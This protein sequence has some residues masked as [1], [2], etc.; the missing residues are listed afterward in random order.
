MTDHDPTNQPDDRAQRA[1][2]DTLRSHADGPI[3][4]PLHLDV[5]AAPSP[6]RWTRWVPAAAVVALVALAVPLVLSQTG[7]GPSGA[8]PQ[9]ASGETAPAASSQA[10]APTMAASGGWRWESYKV[11]SYQ[12][13]TTWGYGYAPDSAWCV[14]EGRTAYGP[15]VDVATETRVVAAILCPRAIPLDRLP[16]FVSVRAAGAADRGY[17]LPAGW[18]AASTELN[19]YRLEVV[20][21]DAQQ[22]VA[23]EIVASV[24]PIGA[25]DPNGCPAAPTSLTPAYDI[26]DPEAGSLCQYDHTNQLLA[27]KPLDT[28][29]AADV[30]T[31]LAAAPNGSGPDEGCSDTRGDTTHVVVKLV[32]DLATQYV[33]VRYAGCRGNGTT[34]LGEPRKLTREACQ[35]IMVQPVVFTSGYGTAATLCMPNPTPS[36]VAPSAKPT[37]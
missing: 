2:R 23:D 28:A 14:G 10:D 6:R 12:V 31:A 25:M 34:G 26:T 21:P 9:Q 33:T 24:R 27:S 4:R 30:R 20:H 8:V 1:L 5:S 3:F 35:A 17:D 11:L 19:G 22:Q 29:A 13:P 32:N 7:G 37:K 36:A 18:S 15:I 16:M